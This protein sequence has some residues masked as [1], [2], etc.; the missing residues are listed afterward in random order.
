MKANKGDY[1][2]YSFLM[3]QLIRKLNLLNKD[4]KVCY[5][6]TIPQCY[7]VETLGQKGKLTMNELSSEL[8]TAISTV[9]RVVD[10][11]VRD[12]IVG[13]SENPKDR[14]KVFIELT[15][16]GRELEQKLQKCSEDNARYILTAIPEEKRENILES[17]ELLNQAVDQVKKKC[18]N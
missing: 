12:G 17:L 13:R 9:T 16:K 15:A 5:G 14:R 18:C 10:L 4:Q 8:G 7:T 1:S 2:R 3:G 6:L 11:L